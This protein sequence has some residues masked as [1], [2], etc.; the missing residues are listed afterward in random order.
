MNPD[1]AENWKEELLIEI[2]LALSKHQPLQTMLV[3]KGARVL[4]ELLQTVGR[5][6]LDIDSNLLRSFVDST[7]DRK[8]QQA[9]LEK[10]LSIAITRH[11]EGQSPVKY[12]LERV[13]IKPQPPK[14]HPYGWDAYHVKVSVIDHTR[15]GVRG[16]P[17]LT[18]D[19]AAPEALL[20]DSIAPLRL[21]SETILAY[22]LERVAGEKLRAFL[23]SLPQYREKVK[24]PGEAVRVKDI[25]DIA[26]IARQRPLDNNEF[27]S[28]A[29]KEFRLACE[30]RF[31]DC[32]GIDSFEQDLATTQSAYENDPTI[33]NEISFNDAWQTIREVTAFLEANAIIPFEFPLP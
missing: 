10:E 13:S 1:E 15:P 33:P 11:F 18:L 12:S 31:I 23:S 20:E 26:R 32:L 7:P 25:F 21:G 22:T 2:F 14:N 27:W 30:F 5:R 6:S 4:N 28:K 19:V 16:L 24:K 3:F 17:S 9:N 8:Q 29:G